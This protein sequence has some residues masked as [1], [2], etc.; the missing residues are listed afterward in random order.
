[1]PGNSAFDLVL[2]DTNFAG[3]P[4]GNPL[5]GILRRWPGTGDPALR[6]NHR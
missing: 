4:G 2:L 1:L 3:I 5:R 6:R